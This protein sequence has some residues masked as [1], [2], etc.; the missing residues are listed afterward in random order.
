MHV[1]EAPAQVSRNEAD[2]VES[3]NIVQSGQ[4]F[5]DTCQVITSVR[6]QPLSGFLK[7]ETYPNKPYIIGK[8][9]YWRVRFILDIDSITLQLEKEATKFVELQ[10]LL[11]IIPAKNNSSDAAHTLY[12]ERNDVFRYETPSLA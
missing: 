9:I 5:P 12:L 6:T 7:D 4:L 10:I 2:E 3:L 1:L 8:R 11:T